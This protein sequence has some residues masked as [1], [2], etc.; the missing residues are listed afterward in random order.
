MPLTNAPTSGN[1]GQ[2]QCHLHKHCRRRT[3]AVLKE[4]CRCTSGKRKY[5]Q[6]WLANINK[7][8][9]LNCLAARTHRLFAWKTLDEAGFLCSCRQFPN[10][11]QDQI[12]NL[13]ANGI[14]TS[15]NCRWRPEVSVGV[16][17]K[18][19]KHKTHNLTLQ[20]RK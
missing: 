1:P 17:N 12:H 8:R 6:F 10:P 16:Q 2:N 3:L 7:N 11:V 18:I 13:F 5:L 9:T 14:V 20:A 4:N 19:P 15:C